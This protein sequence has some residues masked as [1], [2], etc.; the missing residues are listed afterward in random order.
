MH[1]INLL[2]ETFDKNQSPHYN[3]TIQYGLEGCTFCLLDTVKNKF[4]ALRHYPESASESKPEALP[5]TLASD[6]LLTLPYKKTYLLFDAGISTLVP[7]SLFDESKVEAFYQFN[8]G[9]EK[10][11]TIHFNH[12][13][14]ALTANVFSYPQALIRVFKKP[15]PALNV[16]HRT[17]PFIENLM[18]ES[19]KWPRTKCFV[20]I[21]KGIIDIGLA[22]LKKLDFFNSFTYQENTDIIYF[23]LTVLEQFKLSTTFTDVYLSVDTENHEEIFEYLS[24]FLT[25]IKFIRPSE[26]YTYS[27]IFDELQLTRFANLFN[28][29]L[30]V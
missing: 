22:H 9:E 1:Q 10:G 11:S 18:H 25:H 3:L 29:A 24:N 15:F 23:I 2:D 19:A 8:L 16:Y 12:L 4:V 26:K 17:S 7:N 14:E 20:S 13:P 5:I 30:C 27:Y 6:E 28:V 21:H